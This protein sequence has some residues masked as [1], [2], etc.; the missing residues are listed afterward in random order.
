MSLIV[1]END[2][3]RAVISSHAGATL[4]S[5]QVKANN[6]SYELLSA[7]D[8]DLNVDSTPS[9][10]GSFIM[11]PWVNR[12]HE[13]RLV[14]NSGEFQLPVDSGVH[15]IHGTVRQREWETVSSNGESA[16]FRVKL[17]QP[18]PFRGQSLP[19]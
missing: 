3:G 11:A 14:T 5:L 17:E 13:G 2:F 9:G 10:V 4:R 19:S 8:Q 18:W 16:V 1:L 7:A 6:S 15:A 12:I